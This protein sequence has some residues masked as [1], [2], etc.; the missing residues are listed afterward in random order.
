M[1]WRSGRQSK[2]VCIPRRVVVDSLQC[3][4]DCGDDVQCPRSVME[5]CAVY[6]LAEILELV[7]SA[8]YLTVWSLAKLKT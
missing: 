4:R 6:A 8:P 7:E 5:Q 3:D 1:V 2:K